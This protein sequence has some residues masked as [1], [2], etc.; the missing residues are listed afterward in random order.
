M[1]EPVE[2]AIPVQVIAEALHADHL[3]RWGTGSSNISFHREMA[4]RAVASLAD[5]GLVIV[6]AEDLE[7]ALGDATSFQ[8]SRGSTPELDALMTRL[9]RIAE[10]STR[11]SAPSCGPQT[12]EAGIVG[13][14]AD[15][16]APEPRTD[17][18]YPEGSPA[19]HACDNCDGIS[20]ET[21]VFAP[22][23]STEENH[24]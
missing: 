1:S 21:C 11:P 23:P 7:E 10:A 12:P 2:Y 18:P 13:P 22:D 4:E 5:R 8:V 16:N 3:A 15:P 24:G 6:P 19:P 14:P 17:L 9:Y 20:P